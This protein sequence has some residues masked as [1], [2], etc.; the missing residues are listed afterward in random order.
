VQDWLNGK[1]SDSSSSDDSLD[2]AA[3][4]LAGSTG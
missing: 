1:S 4:A 2:Q 3:S